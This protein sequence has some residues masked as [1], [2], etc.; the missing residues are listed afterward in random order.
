MA[1][2]IH[3]RNQ[4]QSPRV[5]VL[6]RVMGELVPIG[7]PITIFNLSQTGFAVLSE[8]MFRAGDR[9][10]FRLTAV[11]GPSVQVTATA[12]H[13]QSMH[14]SPGLYMTGFKFQPDRQVQPSLKPTSAS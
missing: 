5:D 9:M 6:L 2:G 4:R 12:V 8:T 10:E 11:R 7:F 14:D 3:S 1:L 13:T